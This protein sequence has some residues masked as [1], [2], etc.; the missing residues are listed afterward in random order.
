[1]TDDHVTARTRKIITEAY[2]AA[3]RGDAAKLFDCLHPDAEI[4][5]APLLPFGGVY[6]GLEGLEQLLTNITPWMNMSGIEMT[7]II[8]DGEWGC[9]IMKTPTARDGELIDVLELWEL[10]DGKLWR[11][12]VFY[13]DV[14][15][16]IQD[17]AL[18]YYRAAHASSASDSRA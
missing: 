8:A 9:A 6:R 13:F 16:L 3:A 4:F 14:G 10:R 17:E 5:E 1:V 11:A 12:T 2:E 15:P 7:Q 18:R